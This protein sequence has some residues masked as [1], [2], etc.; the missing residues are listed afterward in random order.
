MNKEVQSPKRA[1]EGRI[2]I[3]DDEESIRKSIRI[4]LLQAGYEVVEA[5]DGQ[6]ALTA[7]GEGDN[8]LMVDAILCD[9]RMPRISGVD[10]IAYFRAQYPSIPVIVLTGYP[11]FDL[12]ISLMKMGVRNYLVKP[13][14]KHDLLQ[15]LKAAVEQHVLFKDQFVS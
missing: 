1:R 4:S 15:V 13:V 6:Q 9:I 10:A 11:D 12:A 2:L 14:L 8:P 7:I 5:S 3:V